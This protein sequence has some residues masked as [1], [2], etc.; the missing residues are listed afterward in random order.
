MLPSGV[1]AEHQGGFP[2]EYEH[3]CETVDILFDLLFFMV[4]VITRLL[5]VTETATPSG[6]ADRDTKPPD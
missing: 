3:F 5:N 4:I 2:P 1:Q 6:A